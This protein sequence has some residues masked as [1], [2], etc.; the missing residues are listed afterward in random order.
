MDVTIKKSEID[1][2]A[3]PPPSKSY[4][5]RAFLAAALSKKC[6]IQNPL[7][8]EDTIA[9][10]NACKLLGSKYVRKRNSFEFIGFR[11]AKANYFY[12]ANSGTTLR[13]LIGLTTLIKDVK[14][15]ILDG[16]A[17][18]RS[19]PNRELV[20]ALKNLGAKFKGKDDFKPPVFV[21]GVVFGGEVKIKAKSS[22]FVSSLL[23]TLP[24]AA[25]DSA[26]F[27]EDVKSKPYIDVTL[28]VL[29]EA[30]IKIDVEENNYY[31]PGEQ[32]FN[33][34]NFEVPSDFSSAS[35]LIAAGLMAGKIKIEKM[36]ESM[37]GDKQIIDIA[38][39]MGGKIKWDK[40]GGIITAKKSELNSIQIDASNIPDLVPT[41]SVLASVAKG[42]TEIYN[43]EHLKIKEIDRIDGIYQNLKAVGVD[44]KKRDDGLIIKGGRVKGGVVNSF[45]DHRMA[46]AFSLLGLVAEKGVT[47]KN[48]EVVSVSFP[49]YFESLS[50]IGCKVFKHSQKNFQPI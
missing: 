35:Y 48:A 22:Q 37:Q 29:K 13:F 5:H 9:T 44:V 27:V 42:K 3:V 23:F 17:S 21:K 19:R 41:I 33:L 14:Y 30:G 45:G 36:Y 38:K 7:I 39:K 34:R 43:A 2:N 20:L 8:A 10:L 47:V 28:H 1:G 4:T 11:N 15:S 46:L 32:S 50:K 16:D 40:K 25:G 12:L 31:I 49:N 24:N 6:K 18:L 26:I